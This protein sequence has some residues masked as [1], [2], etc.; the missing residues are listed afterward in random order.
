MVMN[1][2]SV[3]KQFGLI[4]DE[5]LKVYLWMITHNSRI[6]LSTNQ[7]IDCQSLNN[8]WLL[9]IMM[10]MLHSYHS[11]RWLVEAGLIEDESISLQLYNPPVWWSIPSGTNRTWQQWH[12][13]D[14]SRW[15]VLQWESC[16]QDQLLRNEKLHAAS[17]PGSQGS[18][19]RVLLE[20]IWMLGL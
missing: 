5:I 6:P 8:W 17:G 18:V 19:P 3:R 7:D 2:C 12:V 15:P 9:L 14:V 20:D 13:Q 16:E 1:E 10:M 11:W 4:G